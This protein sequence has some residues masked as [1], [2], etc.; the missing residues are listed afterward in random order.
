M[1]KIGINGF[2]RI[3]RIAFR[4]AMDNKD[5]EIVGINDLLDV[6]HLAYMLKY[7][8]VHGRFNKS[9]EVKDGHLV[10]DGKTV[11]ITAE[12]DPKQLKWDAVGAEVIMECTGIFNNKAS[13]GAHIE[14]GAKKVV[15]SAPTKDTPMFVMGVNHKDAKAEDTVVSNASCTTNCLAPLAKVINDNFGIVEGLMTTVHAATSTQFVVDSPSAKNYRVGRSA[16][17]NIIPT[18]TG[19]AVAVTKVIP[20]LKGKLT[21]MAFRVPTADVSVVDLTVRTEKSVSYEEV[22]AAMKKASEGD[23]KG[24]LTYT[25]DEVVSQDFVSHSGICNFDANAGIALNDNFFK[26]IAWY[27][28]EWGFSAKML[29]LAVHIAKV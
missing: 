8:S 5:V 29:D 25:E 16:M 13:A 23:L 22:K 24:I 17:N 18:S 9:V 7:D 21:G 26:L 19:A 10:V 15:I 3:G 2:G 6:D 28:N 11:R 27:D 12:R 20:E 1:T 14:A 4:I